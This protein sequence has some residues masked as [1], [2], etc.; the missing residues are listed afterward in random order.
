MLLVVIL[1]ALF[2]DDFNIRFTVIMCAFGCFG[3]IPSLRD[4]SLDSEEAVIVL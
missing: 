2:S 3:T 4:D 1:H